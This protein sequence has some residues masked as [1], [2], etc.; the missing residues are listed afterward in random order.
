MLSKLQSLFNEQESSALYMST[1]TIGETAYGLR[2]LSDVKRR[3]ALN[4]KF[5][6]FFALVF[7]Q[8]VVDYDAPAAR[9]YG[10]IM[11]LRKESGRPMSLPGSQLAAIP[12][13]NHLA[14]AARNVADFEACGVDLI[15]PF[16][17]A[18]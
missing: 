18:V 10:E 3:T 6:R 1:I 11:G 5:E 17:T 15:D 7:A 8:R 16:S 2:I 14:V 9:V 13:R 4:D 12:R